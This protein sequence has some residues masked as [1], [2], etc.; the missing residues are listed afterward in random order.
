MGQQQLLLIVLTVIIVGIAIIVGIN[1][2][3][4][5]A[6]ESKRNNI[7]DECV[8]LA[9]MAQQFYLKPTSLG[10]GG[11]NFINW[12][13]PDQLKTTANA[14]FVSTAFKDSVVIIGTGNGAVTGSDFV[15]VKM[16]VYPSKYRTVIIK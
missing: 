3:I 6:A 11:N 8:N 5:N 10:G 14:S 12:K 13:I 15:K 2:F 4:T 16:I 7:V 1:L 9:S